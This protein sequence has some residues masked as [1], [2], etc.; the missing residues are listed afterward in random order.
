MKLDNVPKSDTKLGND[1]RVMPLF[2]HCIVVIYPNPCSRF[3]TYGIV[4]GNRAIN[5]IEPTGLPALV[6][7]LEVVRW[8]VPGSCGGADAN[9]RQPRIIQRIRFCLSPID[10]KKLKRSMR[11]FK[12]R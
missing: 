6:F 1:N 7:G 9:I 5:E 3:C 12:L 11:E 8:E 4:C 10:C 2:F